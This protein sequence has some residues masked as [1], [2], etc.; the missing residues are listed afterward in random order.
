MISSISPKAVLIPT[1]SGAALV[2]G[3][4]MPGFWPFAQWKGSF[5][6]E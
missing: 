6:P 4:G 1:I 2:V 3:I 5:F